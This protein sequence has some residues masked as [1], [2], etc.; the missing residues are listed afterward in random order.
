MLTGALLIVIGILAILRGTEC[1][2]DAHYARKMRRERKEM[3]ED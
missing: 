3:E 2:T 1:V